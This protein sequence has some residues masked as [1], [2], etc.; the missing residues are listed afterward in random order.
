MIACTYRVIYGDTDQ[1]GVVYYGNFLRF[2]E[3]GRNEYLRGKGVRYK[4]IEDKFR[5]QFPVVEA[6]VNYRQS[7]RYD[8]LLRIETTLTEARRVSMRFVYRVL[9]D[10]RELATG[11]TVHA[12]INFDGKLTRLPDEL[13]RS[14]T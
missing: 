5:I 3:H 14:L 11:Y 8:D 12:C 9:C 6:H 10:D 2:L 7:A 13:I 4:D 1:M